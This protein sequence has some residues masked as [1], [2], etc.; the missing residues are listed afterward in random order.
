M[1]LTFRICLLLPFFLLDEC[2]L[3]YLRESHNLEPNPPMGYR[4]PYVSKR[5][6]EPTSVAIRIGTTSPLNFAIDERRSC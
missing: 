4:D 1:I 6:L 2:S 5:Y 3:Y